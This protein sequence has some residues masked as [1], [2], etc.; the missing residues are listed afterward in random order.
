MPFSRNEFIDGFTAETKGHIDSIISEATLL[1][2]S[3]ADKETAEKNFK[4]PSD[5]KHHIKN[6][7]L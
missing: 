7:G 1:D 2:S 3:P 6:D 5:N 4:T